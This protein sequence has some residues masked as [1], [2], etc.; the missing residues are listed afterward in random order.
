MTCSPI[1]RVVHELRLS[2]SVF[3]DYGLQHADKAADA[4]DPREREVRE[5]KAKR[6]FEREAACREALAAY[7]AA[8][9]DRNPEGRDGATRLRAEHESDGAPSGA[10]AQDHPQPTPEGT[11]SVSVGE[12]RVLDLL[13]ERIWPRLA[14]KITDDDWEFIGASFKAAN[15]E[16]RRTTLSPCD[17]LREAQRTIAR[18]RRQLHEFGV[19]EIIS[20]DEYLATLRDDK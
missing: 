9:A 10:I 6:N 1:R 15:T 13:F 8:I 17:E 5:R 20:V 16:V 2:A 3:H 11:K 7:D 18:L 4:D 12:L 19:D 14:D